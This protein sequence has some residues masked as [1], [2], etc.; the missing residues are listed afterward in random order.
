MKLLS[1]LANNDSSHFAGT[2]ESRER[3]G[4]KDESTDDCRKARR[5]G[6]DVM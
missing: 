5:D 2:K 4:W 3:T 6:A 1:L